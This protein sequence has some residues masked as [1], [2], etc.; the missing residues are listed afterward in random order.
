MW[1]GLLNAGLRAIGLGVL[2]ST[3]GANFIN[4][5]LSQI[6]RPVLLPF[7]EQFL[8]FTYIWKP[9]STLRV[10][11]DQTA[12]QG[13]ITW[14]IT[15]QPKPAFKQANKPDLPFK[16]GKAPSPL[17]PIEIQNIQL[18]KHGSDSGTYNTE[19][20]FVSSKFEEI[21]SKH[22]KKNPNALT[23]DELLEFVK[24]NR[25]PKD[26]KGW[27]ASYVEWKILHVAAKEKDGTLTKETIRG[28]Y[29]GSLFQQLEKKNSGKKINE[30]T[31]I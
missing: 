1:D 11:T 22:A 25:V 26:Y 27:L 14:P 18:G 28:V 2:L 19:G 24:S 5:G 31:F 4:L 3:V 7:V 12:Y 21:F 6:T 29:D 30:I 16:K 9:Y 15:G 17:L 20:G 10:E 23:Y 13:P 8:L